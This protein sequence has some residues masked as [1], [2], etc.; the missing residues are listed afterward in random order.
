V[1]FGPC[2]LT[3]KVLQAIV[4]SAPYDRFRVALPAVYRVEYSKIGANKIFSHRGTIAKATRAKL[5]AAI[6]AR[7]FNE[8]S[9]TLAVPNRL[10][11]VD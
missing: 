5:G 2:S 10:E 6:R 9:T 11:F 4:A 7:K 3:R 1:I 8:H